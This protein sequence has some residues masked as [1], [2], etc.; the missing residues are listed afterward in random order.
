MAVPE[1]VPRD[2]EPDERRTLRRRVARHYNEKLDGSGRGAVL[3][4]L[5]GLV[6][7]LIGAT[8]AVYAA[9]KGDDKDAPPDA[10]PGAA[11]S[12]LTAAPPAQGHPSAP[13][14]SAPP[15]V[16]GHP[17]APT[18]TASASAEPSP[19]PGAL[20]PG[21]V[22]WSGEAQFATHGVDLDTVPARV[23][24]YYSTDV[25]L[26]R[27]SASADGSLHAEWGQLALWPGPGTPSRQQCA[28]R[29]STHGAERVHVPVDRIGCLTTNKDRVAMFRVTR[30]PDDSFR[31][32][33]Q[34]TVWDS[35]ETP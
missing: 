20:S 7:A 30:Y 12:S 6:A 24:S 35:P 28:E 32:T 19:S 4:A 5:I 18:P 25:D 10:G 33:A 27:E 2:H 23:L 13:S 29:V 14:S 11:A 1:D 21:E 17:V 26:S 22:R 31:V 3:S 16:Q 8:V 9:N 15:P 34:F